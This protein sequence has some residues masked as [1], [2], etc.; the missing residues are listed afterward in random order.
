MMESHIVK[1][2]K[3]EGISS[4]KYGNWRESYPQN[5]LTG[6]NLILKIWKLEGLIILIISKLD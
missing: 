1:I 6:G 5:K 4:S 2:S 3:L